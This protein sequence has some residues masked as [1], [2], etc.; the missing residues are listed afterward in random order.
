MP[1]LRHLLPVNLN[2]PP[3][4]PEIGGGEPATYILLMIT[5][6]TTTNRNWITITILLQPFQ[7]TTNNKQSTKSSNGYFNWSKQIIAEIKPISA[8]QCYRYN[9]ICKIANVTKLKNGYILLETCNEKQSIAVQC[10]EF[11][12]S[13]RVKISPHNSMNFSKGVVNTTELDNCSPEEIIGNLNSAGVINSC[14]I[15]ILRNSQTIYIN[16][17]VL[18]FNNLHIPD[19]INIG[20]THVPVEKYIPLPLC[21]AKC[22]RFG[23]HFS[24]CRSQ[25]PTCARHNESHNTKDCPP[26][27]SIKCANCSLEHPAYSTVW[28]H[29][30][31]LTVL[32]VD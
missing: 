17:Y 30:A 4:K 20:Y 26:D 31:Q 21:C 2:F 8:R 12:D 7:W 1:V 22:Q 24:K 27:A 32:S 29:Q 14:R 6:T 16:T 19:H 18:T 23:H 5:T 11:L 13:I 25:H 3:N 15:T 10:A 9:N 28:L